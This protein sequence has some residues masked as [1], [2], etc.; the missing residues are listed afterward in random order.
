MVVVFLTLSPVKIYT[1]FIMSI[2]GLNSESL[3]ENV[4]NTQYAIRGELYFRAL[5]L[6]A[7]GK[8]V[9]ETW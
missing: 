4:N 9:W 6:Q 2:K 7:Q 8:E 1:L 3:N 5:E